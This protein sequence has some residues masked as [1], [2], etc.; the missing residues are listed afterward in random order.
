MGHTLPCVRCERQF[1]E[2]VLLYGDDGRICAECETEVEDEKAHERKLWSLIV[3]GPVVGFFG[4]VLLGLGL[5][6]LLGL[7]TTVI[8]PFVGLVCVVQGGRAGLAAAREPN[9][10]SNQKVALAISAALSLLWGLNVLAI[11]TVMAI[12]QVLAI[13]VQLG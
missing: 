12:T 6:P 9:V 8:A 2:S 4:A 1:P 5:V 10:T 11:G 3:S 7:L 13:A